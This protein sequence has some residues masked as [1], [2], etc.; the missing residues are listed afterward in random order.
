MLSAP[1]LTLAETDTEKMI[2]YRKSVYKV[3]GKQMGVLG[4][5]N[6]ER[7]PYNRASA[8]LAADT[9]AQLSL[10]APATFSSDSVGI[11]GTEALATYNTE[12]ADFNAAMLKLQTTSKQLASVLASSESFP[13]SDFVAMARSCGGCHDQFK[14]E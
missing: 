2:D 5:M 7:I 4:A 3:I 9:I 1:L 10:I 13:K 11:N 6:R 14:A 12:H 8:K